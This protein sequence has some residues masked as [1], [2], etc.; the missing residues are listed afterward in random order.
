M[1]K[2]HFKGS[3]RVCSLTV[4]VLL[5][6]SGRPGTKEVLRATLAVQSLGVQEFEQF[7]D[8]PLTDLAFGEFLP[9]LLILLEFCPA[10]CTHK[11]RA[12][13]KTNS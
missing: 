13:G 2:N 9:L 10:F 3:S 7:F 5:G 8:S 11:S 6:K 1:K 12:E 4:Y